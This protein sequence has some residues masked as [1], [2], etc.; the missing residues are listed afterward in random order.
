MSLFRRTLVLRGILFR[1]QEHCQ[2]HIDVGM[3]LWPTGPATGEEAKDKLV[4]A[5]KEFLDVCSDALA[6][7][8]DSKLAETT[9]GFGG[10]Q[11]TRAP[12][13]AQS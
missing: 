10:K 8:D 6:T 11:V 1:E 4:A 5:L 2:E 3:T 7:M 9:E 12:G 13:S